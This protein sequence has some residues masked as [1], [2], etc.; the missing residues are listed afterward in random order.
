MKR[1]S[2]LFLS[3]AMPLMMLAQGWPAN[4]GGVMLQGF[5]WDSFVDTQWTN[6]EGEADEIAEYFDLVWVPQSGNC[7]TSYNVMGYAPV[8]WWDQNC[9]FGTEAQLRSMI[10]TYKQKGVGVIADVVINHR[11]SVG[12]NGS[13]VDFPAE[14]YNGVTYQMGLADI[15]K[16]DDG[17]NT[18]KNYPVTGANDTGEDWGGMR[19]LDHTSKNVQDNVIAYL[20]FLKNDLGY[21]GFRYDMTKGYA[22]KYT[23]LYNSAVGAEY[24]VGE[25]WDGNV[26]ALKT[27]LNNAKTD[28]VIQSATFDFT[29]RY[30]VRDACNGNNWS[31]LANRGLAGDKAYRRYAVTFIENHDTQYRS[32]D[33]PNDP[34]KNY[35]QAGNAFILCMP[36]TPCVFLP[37]WKSYKNEI[38]QL[39]S[40]RKLAGITNQSGY[41]ER[42]TAANLYAAEVTGEKGK[43]IVAC[44]GGSYS[45]SAD[46]ALAITGNNYK[47]YAAKSLEAP[48]ASVPSGEFEKAFSVTL[49]ALSS[50][51]GAKLVY[52]TN[53]TEPTAQSTAVGSGTAISI[54]ES[55]T[56]KVGLLS[57]GVVK[58]IITRNYK[59]EAFVPHT[60][61]VHVKDPGW[62]QIYFYA[63]ANDASNTQLN[64]GWPGKVVTDTK[65]IDGVKWYY[66][67]FDIKSKDYSFNIIFD[68]GSSNDQTVDIG[69]INEDKYYELSATKTNGK[70]TVTD[71]TSKI[72]AGIYGPTVED[73]GNAPVR[74]YSIN[75]QMLRSLPKGTSVKDALQEMP[76]GFYIINGKKVVN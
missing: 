27:W 23:A 36:G 60:A 26:T 30:S 14:T 64:G 73:L 6:L 75:G 42:S 76:K 54:K 66:K 34:I 58:N 39:I 44:G 46:Y 3:M 35:I 55:C 32:A 19:D 17:G 56:L 25:Y 1:L 50:D 5:F 20:N 47:V 72:T 57:G 15:C 37:H 24:S 71:V 31:K 18:A 29:T 22:A 45:P 33:S 51:A 12:V 2:T 9:T 8:Y 70:Y 41:A 62:S 68:K 7:N 10:N 53:G 4:Y 28:N 21:T 11:G 69:P 67:S 52:T 61:T 40:M 13:W 63:W 16:N 65:V 48:W 49:T 59:I 74:I 38:K 43:L